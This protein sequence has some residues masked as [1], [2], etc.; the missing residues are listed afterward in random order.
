MDAAYHRHGINDKEWALLEPRLPG[1]LT[2]SGAAF[3]RGSSVGAEKV[4]GKNFWKF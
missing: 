2:G 1:Q 4:L 3:I